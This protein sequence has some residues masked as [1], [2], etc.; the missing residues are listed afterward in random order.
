[1]NI[2]LLVFLAGCAAVVPAKKEVGVPSPTATSGYEIKILRT[3][4]R[5]EQISPSQL[6]EGTEVFLYAPKGKLDGP[7]KAK[8]S[9]VGAEPGW[10]F[11]G[12]TGTKNYSTTWLPPMYVKQPLVFEPFESDRIKKNLIEFVKHIQ[13]IL[14]EVAKLIGNYEVNQFE[15]GVTVTA[16]GNIIVVKGEAAG[17]FKI[18]FS[19]KTKK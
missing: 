18:I 1:M 17:E 11:T 8:A 13:N 19:K 15:V 7:F 10:V 14:D 5:V 16:E 3:P 4:E 9:V 12:P 2:S 6:K